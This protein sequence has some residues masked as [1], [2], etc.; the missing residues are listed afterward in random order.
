METPTE[1]PADRDPAIWARA[2][3]IA[4]EALQKRPL[5]CPGYRVQ[6]LEELREIA[7]VVIEGAIIGEPGDLEDG[8]AAAEWACNQVLDE[9]DARR[10]N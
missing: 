8:A 4:H 5:S 1:H 10:G 7:Y 2:K 3:K 9:D 6:M